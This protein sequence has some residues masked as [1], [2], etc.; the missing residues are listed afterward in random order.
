[1]HLPGLTNQTPG[2]DSVEQFYK[3]LVFKVLMNE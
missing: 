1:V 2:H 3:D